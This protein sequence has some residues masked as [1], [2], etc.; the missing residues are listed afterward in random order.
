M[1]PGPGAQIYRNEAGEVLGWD[2]PGA[3]DPGDPG[4]TDEVQS[5]ADAACEE[6]YER[7]QEDAGEG[8]ER[9]DTYGEYHTRRGRTAERWL[10][11][12]YDQGYAEAES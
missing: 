7:G 8:L 4:D 12:A 3:Y 9:D 2:F 1:F 6:A 11:D 10:Q 5:A